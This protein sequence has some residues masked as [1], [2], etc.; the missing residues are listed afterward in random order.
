MSNR[1]AIILI[2]TCD[3]IV[4]SILNRCDELRLNGIEQT[5]N[6]SAMYALRYN[7]GWQLNVSH[8]S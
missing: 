5:L 3:R 6:I 8:Y 4:D 1:N 2:V 7:T